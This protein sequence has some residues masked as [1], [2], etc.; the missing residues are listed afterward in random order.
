MSDDHMMHFLEGPADGRV[1]LIHGSRLPAAIVMRT[2]TDGHYAVEYPV[3]GQQVDGLNLTD[4]DAIARWHQR[5]SAHDFTTGDTVIVKA[6][7]AR[8]TVFA[9]TTFYNADGTTEE[10]W[11]ISIGSNPALTFVKAEEIQVALPEELE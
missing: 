6:T 2:D 1:E 5:S 4:D 7:G 9:P 8:A 10:G 11:S 3:T